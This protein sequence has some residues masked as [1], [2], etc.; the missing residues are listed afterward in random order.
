MVQFQ[1]IKITGII[2]EGI[3]TPR[4]DGTPGSS[5]YSIPFSLSERPPEEWADRFIDNAN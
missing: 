1:D 4:N 3:N 5:L 2:E